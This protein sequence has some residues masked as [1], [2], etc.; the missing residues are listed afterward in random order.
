MGVLRRLRRRRRRRRLPVRSGKS[1]YVRERGGGAEQ[2]ERERG[3]CT[4]KPPQALGRAS[5]AR[6]ASPHVQK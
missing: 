1:R 3:M 5:S 2:V 6:H 4:R